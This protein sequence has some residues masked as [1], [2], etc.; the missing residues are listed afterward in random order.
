MTPRRVVTGKNAEGNSCF[1]HDGPTPGKLN[2]G[3]L[4]NYEM[5]V[6]DPAKPDPA[7]TKDPAASTTFHLEPPAG[8]SRMHVVTFY[9]ESWKPELTPEYTET[10]WSRF[11]VG[12][13]FDD[14]DKLGMH[15]T[16]T[17]DYG[18]VLSGEI[19]LE[20]DEGK[21]HLKSGDVVVQRGTRHA[22]HV[23]GPEPCTIAFVMVR[24]SNY[25]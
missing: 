25:Q 7:A 4:V 16:C 9:P 1:L 6:D 2:L 20:L 18:I 8:G 5:W 13:A 14:D 3:M 12:D 15:T 24:S 19:D 21:V 11:D 17:I 22:W 23:P 10:A